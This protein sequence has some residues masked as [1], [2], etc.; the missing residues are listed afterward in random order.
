MPTTSF[1]GMGQTIGI[2]PSTTIDVST[3]EN[4]TSFQPLIYS[5]I[6]WRY[7]SFLLVSIIDVAYSIRQVMVSDIE[8]YQIDIF[9]SD[10]KAFI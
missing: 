6:T 5:M 3:I 10:G 8:M 2:V 4:D 9:A 7:F 1:Y